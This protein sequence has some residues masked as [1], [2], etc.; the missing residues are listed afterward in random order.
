L[1][2]RWLNALCC[3]ALASCGIVFVFDESTFDRLQEGNPI[4]PKL[5]TPEQ[6]KKSTNAL[7]MLRFR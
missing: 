7:S 3:I 6:K 5:K 2:W 4:R 1:G